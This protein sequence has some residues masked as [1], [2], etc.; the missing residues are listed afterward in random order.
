MLYMGCNYHILWCSKDFAETL[1][2]VG[3]K[4]QLIL[5]EGKTHTDIFLQVKE[6]LK[7]FLL[8]SL[9]CQDVAFVASGGLNSFLFLLYLF[10]N[11]SKEF[12]FQ[13]ITKFL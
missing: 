12:F 6:P 2:K 1:Q 13:F 8:L 4:A 3:V 9:F 5:Y 7:C 10:L 11:V